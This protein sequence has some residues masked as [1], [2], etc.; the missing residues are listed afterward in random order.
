VERG[1]L[2]VPPD[3][4][5]GV[6]LTSDARLTARPV[7]EKALTLA[8]LFAHYQKH[9]LVGA[10]K[11]NTRYTED[12][13]I[14]HLLRI[15]G[16][17]TTV[18]AVTKTLIQSY[19]NAR[20]Q[21]KRRGGRP[22]S[23]ATIAEEIGTIATVGN[24]WGLVHEFVAGPPPVKDLEYPKERV[25]PPFKTWEQIE[26]QIRRGGLSKAEEK[27]LWDR[28]FLSLSELQELLDHVRTHAHQPYA[29]VMFAIAAF[30]GARRSEILRWRVED[31]DFASETVTIREKKKDRAKELTFRT[32]PM[33]PALMAVM[34]EWLAGH[35][36]GQHTVCKGSGRP[37]TVQMAAKAF[38]LAVDGSKWQVLLG[39]HV[40]RHSFASNCALK[41]VDSRVIDGW[42]GHQTQ[43]MRLRDQHLF[44]EQQQALRSV[45]G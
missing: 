42:M 4:D 33:T 10:K 20:A 14:A 17:K 43:E 40:L 21:E 35:P 39:W 28:L 8:E 11:K 31:F 18:R 22:V 13:H 23:Q 41:G 7:L 32:V 2:P 45:F 44:P 25:K 30:T 16:G 12:I 6:F 1:R 34:Q 36:G 3:A 26:R 9:H 38:R 27:D 37:L 15:L 24:R 19:V 5:L 29:Y